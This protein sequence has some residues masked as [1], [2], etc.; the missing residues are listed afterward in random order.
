MSRREGER[1]EE[2]RT[3]PPRL[4]M[5][6]AD[7]DIVVVVLGFTNVGGATTTPGWDELHQQ[8]TGR[9]DK[10]GSAYEGPGAREP[11][12]PMST[13]MVYTATGALA[14]MYAPTEGAAA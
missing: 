10:E 12:S 7:P 5:T 8:E 13:S 3:K 4:D 14:A 11:L 2:V 6:T 9:A 1:V